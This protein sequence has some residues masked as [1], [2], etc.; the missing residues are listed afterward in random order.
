[1]GMLTVA[2]VYKP[3]G[4]FSDDYVYRLRDGVKQ[5]CQAEHNFVCLTSQRLK[6]VETIPL[7]QDWIGWWNK[8]QL[9]KKDQFSGPVVYFDLDTMIVGDITDIVSKPQEFAVLSDFYGKH[10]INSGVMA[11]NADKDWSA[12]YELFDASRVPEYSQSM[13]KWGDQGWIENNLLEPPA[14]LQDQFPGKIVSYKADIRKQ[15]AVPEGAAIVCFHGKPRP[16][17]IGWRL[18]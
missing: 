11:W 13:E 16:H 14:R 18:P 9:F 12:L 15:N 7:A 17:Q 5:H 8:L 2:C 4:G 6:S 3:G 1:M 10:R